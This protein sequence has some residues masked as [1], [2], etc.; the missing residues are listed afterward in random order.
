MF[1]KFCGNELNENA[2]VCTKCGCPITTDNKKEKKS[3]RN[4]DTIAESSVL[5]KTT[6]ILSYISIALIVFSF[7]F[8]C[9]SV[10]GASVSSRF[11]L[12]SS[13]SRSTVFS[14][15]WLNFGCL[16]VSF[17]S[18]ILT[19]L[20]SIATFIVGLCNKNRQNS[21]KSNVIFIIAFFLLVL[22][23]ITAITHF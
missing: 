21:F 14:S 1:C 3:T 19:F 23:I 6:N 11:Y 22:A 18:T 2:V 8:W 16:L 17:I 20:V 12:G 13:V 7:F 15:L 5:T 4:N 9:L 10:V